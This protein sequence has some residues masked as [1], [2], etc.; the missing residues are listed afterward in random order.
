MNNISDMVE[1]DGRDFKDL[2]E[3]FEASIDFVQK[4]YLNEL[5]LRNVVPIPKHINELSTRNN[6]RLFRMNKLVFDKNENNLDKLMSIYNTLGNVNG[7]LVMIINSDGNRTDLY[8]GTR[9]NSKEQDVN[10]SKEALRKSFE[11]NF[12]G[13]DIENL[14]NTEIEKVISSVFTSELSQNEKS[15]SSVSGVPSLKD[16]DKTKFVQGLEKLVEAMKGEEFSAIFIADPVSYKNIEEIKLGYENLYSQLVPFAKCDLS[17]NSSD[18]LAITEGISKGVTETINESLTKTQSY[19]QGSSETESHSKTHSK[20]T[21]I[22]A[23]LAGVGAAGGF[24]V[25][26]PVGAILVGGGAG[27]VGSLI[28]SSTDGSTQ[29]HS[30]TT[31]QSKTDGESETRGR[32]D[33]T[34]SQESNSETQTIGNSRNLQIQFENK[35]VTNL[36]QK[37]EEQLVRLKSSEDFGMWSCAC[38]FI[39]PSVQTSRVA[40][41]TFKAIMRGENSAIENSFINTWDNNN[42]VNL[43]EVG[44]YLKK[45]NHPLI[46]MEV[47]MGLNLPHVSPGSLINGKELAIQ[48]GLPQKSISGLP[49]IETAEFGRDVVTYDEV[50]ESRASIKLGNVFHMGKSENTSVEIDIKSLAMHTFITGSTG[51]GKSNTIYQMLNELIRKNIHFLVIEPAKGEYKNIF[52][53]RKDVHVFGTNLNYTDLLQINPF[54]FPNQV[55]VLEHID[56]IIEIFNACWSMYAAMPAVLKE[57]IERTYVS[58]GWD[59]EESFYIGEDIR[60]PTFHDLLNILPVVIKE[61]AYSEEVKSNYI[62]ALVTRVKSLTNGLFGKIF[63]DD[64]IENEILFDKNCIIDLSRVGSIETKSL[65]MGILFT[66]LQEYRMSSDNNLNIDLKHVTVL[67]EAHHLLRRV[68]S[69]QSQEGSNLQGKSVEMIAN[70]IAEMRTY[71]EGFIIADQAPNLLDRSVIR[72]TNTKII[73]R[74]PDELDRSEVGKTANLNENQINELPKLRTGVAAIYQNNWL[75][76][77][78]CEV[79]NFTNYQ[80]YNFESKARTKLMPE[81]KVMLSKLLELLLMDRVSENSRNKL[82][83]FESDHLK[84]WLLGAPI[85]HSIKQPIIQDLNY[86][87]S[88]SKM[89]LWEQKNFVELSKIVSALLPQSMGL[90]QYAKNAMN[91]EEWNKRYTEGIRKYITFAFREEYEFALMQCLLQDKAQEDEGFRDFYYLW[92]EESKKGEAN[93]C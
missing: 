19:T 74:L 2:D 53:G 43:L 5:S 31:N 13:S 68:S 41:S 76:P 84:K 90:I 14:T 30:N 82:S 27:A 25:G 35:T 83:S 42:K 44:K 7:S 29:S 16:Q 86:F 37:I 57:A 10:S 11:G 3:A 65:I 88:N 22:G 56:R 28:G 75:Q 54:R 33:S 91:L 73:L 62:G 26:G 1:I 48:L 15:V 21:N 50:L 87:D 63:T 17:F 18:S 78:L 61:S 64:E 9:T 81:N 70:A 39:A 46:E 38:Y 79:N 69:E 36:L 40:A 72:N 66:R 20:T 89:Q 60:Y 58:I 77:V 52:G 32:S 8:L 4:N 23:A 45:L 85:S 6:I 12:P 49:V 71:G 93:V 67:E 92:V 51:S 80:R 55:H 47:I 34:S 59:I 24:L